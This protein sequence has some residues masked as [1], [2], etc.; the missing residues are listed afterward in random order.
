M[1]LQRS[2]ISLIRQ[3]LQV[4]SKESEPKGE[5]TFEAKGILGCRWPEPPNEYYG[6][7][8]LA[9]QGFAYSPGVMKIFR[10]PHFL[11]AFQ[12]ARSK[13]SS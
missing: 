13:N 1:L 12:A 10:A 5:T 8:M 2:F 7:W 3:P 11:F 6:I 4:F 9:F